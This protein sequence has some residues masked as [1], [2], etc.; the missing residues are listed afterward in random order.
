MTL[1]GSI[2]DDVFENDNSVKKQSNNSLYSQQ[3]NNSSENPRQKSLDEK[4]AVRQGL[5]DVYKGFWLT[6]THQHGNYGIYKAS[7]DSLTTDGY[8][9]IVAIVPDD[10]TPISSEKLLSSLKW[11]IFQSRMTNNIEKEFNNQQ[12]QPQSYQ[13]KRENILFDVIRLQGENQGKAIYLPDTL[14]LKVEVLILKEN[15]NFSEEGTVLAALEL[16]Q[17]II[18]FTN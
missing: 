17:T 14:P 6:K 10:N 2:I 16:Y 7:I 1:K 3:Y 8:K 15:E 11:I 9:Y 5:A 4:E 13:I 18:S 12:V